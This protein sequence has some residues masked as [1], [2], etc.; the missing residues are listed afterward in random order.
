MKL[1][2][3]RFKS[4]HG[5]EEGTVDA[6]DDDSSSKALAYK[7][8]FL[9]HFIPIGPDRI[10]SRLGADRYYVTRKYDG[11]YAM[12]VHDRGQ[13][14]TINR[15]GRVRR[16]IPCIEEAGRLLGAAGVAEAMIAAEIYVAGGQQR[17]RLN[18]LL[19]ALADRNRIGEL[20]LA[21][22]DLL[23]LDGRPWRG[24][25]FRT[26]EKLHEL[27]LEGEKV[28]EV[29]MRVATSA[30][31]VAEIYEAWVV[32]EKAEG[33]VVRSE[34][35]FVFKIKPRHSFD[36][37]VIGF[38]E[39]VGG[40]QGQARSLLLALMPAE[41]RYQVV[42]RVGSGMVEEVRELL[43]DRLSKQVLPSE[44]IETDANFVAFRMVRPDVVVEVT[45][46]D[47][48][49]ETG[50]G[51]RMNAVLEIERGAYRIVR[52]VP[53][54]KFLA[55]V[56]VRIRTDKRADAG[57]VRLGQI[58]R[59]TSPDDVLVPAGTEPPKSASLPA[60]RL[61]FREVFRKTIGNKVLVQKYMVWRTNKEQ[62]G[63][64]P[65]YV[66]YVANYSSGR[67]EPLQRDVDVSDSERQI[68]EMLARKMEKNLKGGWQKVA[69][70]GG[71]RRMEP[72]KTPAAR[73]KKAEA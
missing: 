40:E 4:L 12:I 14:V 9:K 62:T 61:I 8:D 1:F 44:F 18:D 20:R 3:E 39:G 17:G 64:Y 56:F 27:F 50:A 53:G 67:L 68:R 66:L 31:Q 29:E 60:S 71:K 49:F 25:Y 11:E 72:E 52:S 15:S 22:F 59:F 36:A 16:G 6:I 37:A 26:W 42:G 70:S 47:L 13:T 57:D 58:E 32:R 51:P 33:L 21:A 7:K 43:F 23:E 54:V 55:P 69:S 65:A 35:P 34:M 28:H 45:V 38:S 19:S 46:G 10:R 30:E 41:G 2:D 24:S 48:L 5:Y 73:R 63:D